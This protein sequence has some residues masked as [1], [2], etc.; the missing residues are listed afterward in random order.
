[1]LMV[2]NWIINIP[3]FPYPPM[4]FNIKQSDVPIIMLKT[5]WARG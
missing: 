2:L 5:G 4:P 1:M 3:Q